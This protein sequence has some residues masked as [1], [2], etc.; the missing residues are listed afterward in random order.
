MHGLNEID[1][2]II[3][4]I[5]LSV[6]VGLLRGFVRDSMSLM[7]WIIAAILAVSY[8]EEVAAWFTGISIVGLRLLLAFISIILTTLIVGG[9][10]S[11]LL[12]KLI[13]STKFSITDRITGI[14]FGLVRGIAITAFAILMTVLIVKP[15]N[16]AKNERWKNSILIPQFEPASLWIR[17]QLPEEILKFF[18]DPA[19]NSDVIKKTIEEATQKT[20]SAPTQDSVKDIQKPAE[21]SLEEVSILEQPL[22]D[23]TD[24]A[25]AD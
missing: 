16:L 20:T 25:F 17:A 1:Y 11:H 3:G 24:N 9:I 12:S 10:V 4:I 8:C 5:S 23:L 13:K 7:T 6:L 2:G 18:E 22:E 21:K 15:T 14:L 19:K